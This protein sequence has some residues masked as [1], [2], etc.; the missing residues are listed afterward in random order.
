M[1]V[2]HFACLWTVFLILDCL[3]QPWYED[4]ALSY[5]ILFGCCLLEAYYLLS[6]EETEVVDLDKREGMGELRGME[7]RKLIKMYC[8]GEEYVFNKNY[9]MKK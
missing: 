2:S 1:Y 5:S 9:K 8:I 6:E 7:D 3:A 4:F